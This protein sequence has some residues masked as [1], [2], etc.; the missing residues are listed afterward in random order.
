MGLRSANVIAGNVARLAGWDFSLGDGA[1]HNTAGNHSASGNAACD[2]APG[3]YSAR[4]HSTCNHSAHGRHALGRD[5]TRTVT[6][7]RPADMFRG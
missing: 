1:G 7:E 6:C 4:N 2:Y 3:D 5:S